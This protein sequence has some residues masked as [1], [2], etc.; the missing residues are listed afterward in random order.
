MKTHPLGHSENYRCTI[1]HVC[2]IVLPWFLEADGSWWVPR[3]SNPVW[4]V[5]N[6]LGGFDSYALPP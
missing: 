1:G 4:G 3:T 6:V 5:T 2:H